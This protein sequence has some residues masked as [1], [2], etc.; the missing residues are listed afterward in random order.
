MKVKGNGKAKILSE[1]E[2]ANIFNELA[3]RPKYSCLFAICLFTGCRISEAIKLET[4]DISESNITFRKANTKGKLKTRNVTI[5]LQLSPYLK[6]YQPKVPGPLFGGRPGINKF[7]S[8]NTADR[9]LREACQRAGVAGAST[10]SFRRTALTMMSR[11]NV[12]L[13]TIQEISGHTDLGTLQRYLEVD[14]REVSKAIAVIR[15]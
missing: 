8:R 5:N 10:H 14:P 9:V 7:L 6:I 2:L 4:W 13:R 12:P 3:T 11:E 15:F 1:L